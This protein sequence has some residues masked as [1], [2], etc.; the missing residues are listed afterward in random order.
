MSKVGLGKYDAPRVTVDL[1][2][3]DKKSLK[4]IDFDRLKHTIKESTT[5]TSKRGLNELMSD[6]NFGRNSRGKN[7]PG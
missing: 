1:G 3:V 5:V 6:P 7:D 2:G 4:G